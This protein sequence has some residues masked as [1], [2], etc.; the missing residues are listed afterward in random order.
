[1]VRV[2]SRNEAR[3][4]AA[5]ITNLPEFLRRNEALTVQKTHH[6]RTHRMR[7]DCVYSCM[8]LYVVDLV[9]GV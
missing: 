3:R 8:I 6:C 1:M 7:A 4:I 2:V 5:N 9:G